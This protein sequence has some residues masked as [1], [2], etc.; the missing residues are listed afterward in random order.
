MAVLSETR[1]PGEIN[2]GEM[3]SLAGEVTTAYMRV[4]GELSRSRVSA[5]CAP[6]LAPRLV[7]Y[8]KPV[9][10]SLQD[11]LALLLEALLGIPPWCPCLQCFIIDVQRLVLLRAA[12]SWHACHDTYSNSQACLPLV[13][14]A[15]PIDEEH[16]RERDAGSL[17]ELVDEVYQRLGFSH[18]QERWD[19]GSGQAD[20]ARDDVDD[21]QECDLSVKRI[22]LTGARTFSLGKSRTARVATAPLS[23]DSGTKLMSRPPTQV[24]PAGSLTECETLG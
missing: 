24:K 11:L 5:H 10:A 16:L 3:A 7:L 13:Q 12:N 19:V 18:G 9:S 20:T 6:V 22:R 8:S 1:C 14:A 15:V 21:L 4:R 17:T 2:S 23:L